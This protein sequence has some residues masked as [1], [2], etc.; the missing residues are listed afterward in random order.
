MIEE[1]SMSSVLIG[2]FEFSEDM[3]FDSDS[4]AL[5]LAVVS[6]VILL[7]S[8]L[9]VVAAICASRCAI[10]VPFVSASD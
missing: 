10:S 4:F 3:L 7:S 9:S 1:F 2:K 8:S 5:I 6:A